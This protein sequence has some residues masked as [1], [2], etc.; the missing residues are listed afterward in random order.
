MASL[1]PESLFI[2][3]R[4]SGVVRQLNGIVM[5]LEEFRDQHPHVIAPNMLD[6]II[7][8]L[9][10]DIGVLLREVNILG[11]PNRKVLEE[12]R[13]VCRSCNKIFSAP[14]VAGVCDECRGRGITSAE[15]TPMPAPGTEEIS[16]ESGDESGAGPATSATDMKAAP[17]GDE[18][19]PAPL[20]ADPRDPFSKP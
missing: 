1:D 20:D 5:N 8:N 18:T 16:P 14:I 3:R 11:S 9:K 19:L 15:F 4:L 12:R 7:G 2:Q 13:Y 10:D 17:E 6:T